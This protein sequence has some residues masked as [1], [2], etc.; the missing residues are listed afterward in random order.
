MLDVSIVMGV[1]RTQKGTALTVPAYLN[2]TDFYAFCESNT[3]SPRHMS[4][5]ILPVNVSEH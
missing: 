5:T 1:H 3:H 4:L 2:A